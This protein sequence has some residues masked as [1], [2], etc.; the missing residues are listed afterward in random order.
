MRR[1]DKKTSFPSS[2]AAAAIFILLTVLI[3][4]AV[5]DVKNAIAADKGKE[6]ASKAS[7]EE[8]PYDIPLKEIV[9]ELNPP[10]KLT[11]FP[12][13]ECHNQDLL[14]D[15]K[16]R[17]L[18]EP[19]DETP[20]KFMNHDSENRWCL[21]CHDKNNRDK[22]RLINGLP[23]NFNEY[24][25]LCEQCHRRVYRE[26]K[27]GVHGK[28]TGRWDGEKQYTHC[29]QCHNPHDPPF[30]PLKPEPPPRKPKDIRVTV[31]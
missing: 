17:E 25:R 6:S 23:V 13:S 26:W 11:L 29:A 2:L 12:C 15:P 22:L 27:M 8:I 20:G 10:N 9:K 7:K 21:D 19:H 18:G 3:F 28:R 5:F 4:S 1:S 14:P 16:R 24:Y 31:K 30:K